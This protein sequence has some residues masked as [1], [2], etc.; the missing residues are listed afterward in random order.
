VVVLFSDHGSLTNVDGDEERLSNFLAAITPGKPN[1]FGDQPSPVN[2]LRI[3]FAEYLG[4]PFEA[5]PVKSFRTTD[6]GRLTFREVELP[7]R[8]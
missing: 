2:I 3:V 7:P 6:P 1:L 5:L 8:R 4:E